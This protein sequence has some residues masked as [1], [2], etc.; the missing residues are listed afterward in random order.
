MGRL[1]THCLTGTFTG[2]TLSTSSSFQSFGD[3]HTLDND[4][5]FFVAYRYMILNYA[6]TA[7]GGS[8]KVNSFKLEMND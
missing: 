5:Q 3:P 7:L 6:T 2:K 8:I 4:W 1:K